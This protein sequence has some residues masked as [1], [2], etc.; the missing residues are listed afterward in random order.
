[1]AELDNSGFEGS[2]SA[3][4]GMSR[5]EYEYFEDEEG[6]RSSSTNSDSHTA[7]ESG[8]Q[9]YQFEPTTSD[10]TDAEAMIMARM[11]IGGLTTRTGEHWLYCLLD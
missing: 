9:P 10:E 2:Y 11:K 4:S 5:E 1:M 7:A 6:E 3:G 8:I